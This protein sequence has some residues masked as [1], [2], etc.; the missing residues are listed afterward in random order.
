MKFGQPLQPLQRLRQEI[1]NYQTQ[2]H[3]EHIASL[4]NYLH[5][6][7][8]LIPQNNPTITRPVMRHPDLQ[9]NNI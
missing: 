7:S 4:R 9:P 2:S 3:F 8:D 1:Y 6:A 5:I